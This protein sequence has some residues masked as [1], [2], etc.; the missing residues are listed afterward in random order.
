MPLALALLNVSN[1]DRGVMDTLSRL[2]HDT[3]ADVAANAVLALGFIGA[4]TNNARLAGMLRALSS[5]YYKE[6]TLLYLVR[7]AQVRACAGGLLAGAAV[8]R[9]GE[10]LGLCW[11]GVECGCHFEGS[12][13]SLPDSSRACLAP[14]LPAWL[15]GLVHMG[16]GLLTLNPYH[17]DHTL[18]N[19]GWCWA[20][21]GAGR[22]LWHLLPLLPP[23]AILDEA[24]AAIC[25]RALRVWH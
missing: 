18:L 22:A 1:P 21:G 9:W 20:L 5:Y 12:P 15:Q 2:S 3:D 16:K 13:G 24:A 4:G 8:A 14:R 10:V 23:L 7:V 17:S 19:G 11:C 6:P 25:C